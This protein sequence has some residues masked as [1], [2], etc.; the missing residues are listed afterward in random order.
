MKES[1]FTKG[2]NPLIGKK[3]ELWEAES[4]DGAEKEVGEFIY[5]L[6][7]LIKPKVVVET[8]CYKGDTTLA[9][10][11]ALQDNKYGE[12]YSC[13]IVKEF[14][15]HTQKRVNSKVLLKTGI[16]LIKELG[17]KIE[18]A[19]ID[20]GY[21]CREEEINELI[22]HLSKNQMFALHDTAPQHRAMKEMSE[23]FDLRKVYFNT[24]RG[25]TLYEI[26]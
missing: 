17:D 25:L 24:P 3:D 21:L 10:E 18:F 12:L 15:E 26:S 20:S 5:G 14:V 11:R 6:I 2:V 9:I 19:F 16:E 23:K 13:D 4:S 7:R 8:G 1:E 22:K